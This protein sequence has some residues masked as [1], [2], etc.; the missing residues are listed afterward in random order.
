[1]ADLS[2]RTLGDF[3]LREKIA[4]G[5]GGAV[6]RS[7]QPALKREVLVKVLHPREKGDGVA[8]ERFKREAQLASRLDHPYAAHVHAFGVVEAEGEEAG[9]RWIAMELVQGIT[10]CDWLKTRGPMSL[11][12]FVPFFECVAEVVHAAHERGIIHRDLKPSN[13]MVI[14]RGGRLFPKLLDFGIAKVNHEVTFAED[15]KSSDGVVTA[16]LRA[17]PR[18]GAYRTGTDPA[19][20][21][22]ELTRSGVGFGS[23][24]YMAPEQWGNACAVGRGADIYSLGVVIY[25]AL[26]GRRPYT[27]ESADEY[28]RLHCH[29][30]VPEIGGEFSRD[31]NRVLRCALSKYTDQ[32]QANVLELASDLRAVLRAS[33]REQLRSSAQQWEDR[34]RAPGLLWGGDV[35][36]ELEGLTSRASSGEF[37][38]LECSFVAASLQRARRARWLWRSLAVLAVVGVFGV[39]LY[40]AELRTRMARQ[41]ADITI[42]QADIEQG[43]QALLHSESAEAQLHLTAAYERDHSP[44]IAFMLARSLQPRLA[45]Q[46]RFASVKGRMWSATFS[47]GGHRVVTTDDR[48]AQVWDARTNELLFTLPHGDTVY[49]AAYSADGSRL[50]T[51]GG[52]G[53]VKI[54]DAGNGT[55]VRA[56][57]HDGTKLRYAVVAT[58]PDG[59]LVAA[60]DMTGSRAHVWDA[61]TGDPLAELRNDASDLPSIAFNADGHWL[62][63]SGGDDVRVFDT[64]TWVQAG[65]ITGPGIRSLSWDPTGPRLLTGTAGGDASIWEIPS[66]ARTRHLREVGEP[67][68]AV[69]FAPNGEMVVTGSRDG[70]EQ[71]WNAASGALQ[72]QGNYLHSKILSVEFDPASKL[73]VAASSS[74]TVV[75]TDAAMGIPVA[76]LDGPQNVV[77]VAHFDVTS[78]RVVGASWD[79]TARIWDATS[80]YRRWSSPPASDDCGLV[81]SLVPDRRFVAVG[82]RDHATRV[83]DTARDQL[84]A[85]LPPV[86]QV[87]G[88]FISAFPAVSAEGDRAAIAHGN[89][90]EVYELPG[91]R[92]LRTIAHDAAISTVAFAA[93]GHDLVSGAVDGS[94]L[95][96]RDGREPIALPKFTDGID[97]AAILADGR[98][99]AADAR[100]GLRVYALDPNVLLADL[101]APARAMVLRDSSDGRRL[102]SVPSYAK[103]DSA[104]LW[105]LDHYRLTAQ[106]EGHIGQ[107]RSARFVRGDHQILTTGSDGTARLWDGTTGQLRQTY[108]GS[109]R[110][111]ADATLS[112]D[113]LMV[114]AGDGDGLLR[115]WDVASTRPIWT[116]Q[117][118]RSHLIGVHFEGNDIVTRGFGGDFSRWR[119]PEPE[120]AIEECSARRACAI[121]QR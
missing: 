74:G 97:T 30:P 32:R 36:A 76:M 19:N 98:V 112:P 100:P 75:V 80:P 28:N 103:A 40:R 86:T 26:S 38:P 64:A 81:A 20:A 41:I 111:L 39:F 11:G 1:M 121:V 104:V 16:Q 29:A 116:L 4:E 73:V 12:E 84:L 88:D 78:R 99:V 21:K 6:Y 66:F 102:I 48:S 107:I 5:G 96:T 87:P 95:V 10:L 53:T 61:H 90:V 45:E 42:T 18:P 23:G 82:C 37:S 43:R 47:P 117:A 77:R 33:D 25:E 108:R 120:R 72:S 89:A 8:L 13:I 2:G 115:F 71:S 109:R 93:A 63:T 68:D 57:V 106:L 24:P 35:L 56:L 7:E 54:W 44:S 17:T 31:L 22:Y 118:H 9:L 119:L 50:V 14:E 105:D 62:A 51:A 52:D 58:S 15:H 91:G 49:H 94:L 3:V 85:E 70:A 113:G 59:K 65:T 34:D 92:L 55:L 46:A 101:I 67:V 110:F 114:V 83:W 79:G 27:A 69:A 60:I